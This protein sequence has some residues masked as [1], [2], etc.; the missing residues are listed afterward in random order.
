MSKESR[1]YDI[2]EQISQHGEQSVSEL[3]VHFAVSEM[4]IRRD[5]DEMVLRGA[6]LRTHGGGA[7]V[8]RVAFDFQFM[9]RATDQIQEKNQIA[10]CA[11][12]LVQPGMTVL[13]DSGTTT[14]AIARALRG[15]PQ[16]KIITT[17]LPI[18]SELQYVPELDLMLLGGQLRR[19]SPDL[20]GPLTRVGLAQIQASIAFLGADGIDK[21]GTVYAP[22]LDVAELLRLM[23]TASDAVWV[24]ADHQKLGRTSTARVAALST[25]TGMITDAGADKELL[26]A[27]R[28]KKCRVELA[29]RS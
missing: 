26:Q 23:I 6:I 11:A 24:V 14:L 8:G 1:Q 9:G 2:L 3:A 28:R 17:S 21:S 29:V 4:T 19:E 20:I 13:L 7:P 16:L 22:S 18:A 25:L 27:L 15:I 10:E 12:R 5:L